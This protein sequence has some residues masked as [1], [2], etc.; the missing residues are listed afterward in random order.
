MDGADSE[1]EMAR[2]H[3]AK[4]RLLVKRQLEILA[5][6]RAD[7]HPTEMAE[8]LLAELRHTQSLHEEHLCRIQPGAA[9][10][11]RR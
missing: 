8:Q 7:E 10:E 11:P 3:V 9:S 4:G 2:R 1:L 6:L 5:E